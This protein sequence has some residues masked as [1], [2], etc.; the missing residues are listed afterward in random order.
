MAQAG[1]SGSLAAEL[2]G[3]ANGDRR[4]VRGGSWNNDDNNLRA[5]NRNRN[6][7]DNRNDNQGLRVVVAPQLLPLL[8]GN[9]VRPRL[10]PAAED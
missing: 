3:V 10:W 7:P 5:A 1:R 6:N 8:A 9:A 2:W 4:V